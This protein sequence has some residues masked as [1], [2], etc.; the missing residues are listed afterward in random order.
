[1]NISFQSAALFGF[2]S[3]HAVIIRT[4]MKVIGHNNTYMPTFPFI[5]HSQSNV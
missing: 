3:N 5:C 1:M 4:Q 2:R